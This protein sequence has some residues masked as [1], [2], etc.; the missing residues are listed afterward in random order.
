MPGP[1]RQSPS[2]RGRDRTHFAVGGLTEIITTWLHGE[3]SID[4]EQLIDHVTNLG[5]TLAALIPKID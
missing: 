2:C 4:A 1:A 5:M 3:L